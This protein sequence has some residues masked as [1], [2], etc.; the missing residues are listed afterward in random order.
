MLGLLALPA[1]AEPWLDP[2]AWRGGACARADAVDVFGG[3]GRWLPA[4]AARKLGEGCEALAPDLAAEAGEGAI[5][6][7]RPALRL[8]GG[9]ATPDNLRGDEEGGLLSGTL[10]AA[11]ALTWGGLS[12]HVEPQLEGGALGGD[13]VGHVRLATLYGEARWKGLSLG[14]GTR[15][16][17]LGPG[18]HGALVLSDN[19]RPPW[20]ATGTAEGRLPGWF[21]RLGRFRVEAGAGLLAEPRDD[22]ERPG[23]LLMDFR[24]LPV[25]W[26]EIGASRLSIFGGVGRPPVDVGQLLIP[27]EP[28]VYG[29]PDKELPDQNELAALDVRVSLPLGKWTGLPVSLVEGWWQ[30]GGEDM[31]VREL[32]PLPYPSLAGVGNLYGG[33]VTVG[34]VSVTAEYSALLDDYFRWYVGH[35]VYH[36]GFTQDGRVLGHFG[37]P[38]SETLFGAVAWEGGPGRARVWVD[39]TRRVGVIEALNDKLFTFMT[40]ERRV[41][42]GVDAAWRLPRGGWIGAGYA[43]EHVTGDD[44]VPGAVADRHRVYVSAAPAAVFGGGIGPR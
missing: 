27:S 41:R 29:D 22:V 9:D 2:I 39:R 10:G 14:V 13:P 28:H 12:L 3:D 26:I 8:G 16:R 44:F 7:V 17:W 25:P 20:L 32:G 35:R 11:G 15:D 30:Y 21:D 36:D 37:G 31:I 6:T 40:E 1:A 23:L 18:R 4:E 43:Y 19:A 24:W 38:D 34:P 33:A 42:G 5:W